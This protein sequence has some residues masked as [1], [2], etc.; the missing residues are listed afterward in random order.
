[1]QGSS[2]VT[3]CRE[4]HRVRTKRDLAQVIFRE[5]GTYSLEDL[6]TLRGTIERDLR[7]L[8]PPYRRKLYPKMI[9][10]IFGTHHRVIVYCREGRHDRE[11]GPLD[12]H[13]EEFCTMIDRACLAEQDQTE[14]RRS[15]LYYLLAAFNIFVLGVPGH[16]IGTPFPGGQ[17]VEQRGGLY[18]CPI[19]DKEDDVDTSICPYC[20]AKQSDP[21][22]AAR[23]GR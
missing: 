23:T 16:P 19:R 12:P 7:H 1:V 18:L 8:P 21:T 15:L 10:Q 20:P 11:Q 17:Q 3:T 14:A 13:F 9:E 5:A 6:Q 22:G 4:L 2:I